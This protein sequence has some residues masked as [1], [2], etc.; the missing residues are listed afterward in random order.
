MAEEFD[1]NH[2]G[3]GTP[4][5]NR[6]I[7]TTEI[8]APNGV[9]GLDGSG[10][11][12][13]SVIP[14]GTDTKKTKIGVSDT[15]EGFLNDKLVESDSIGKIIELDGGTGEQTMQFVL[16]HAGVLTAFAQDIF[17]DA[18]TGSTGYLTY[19][20]EGIVSSVHVGQG[21]SSTSKR[22]AI[23]ILPDDFRNFTS[24]ALSIASYR[25]GTPTSMTASMFK[26]PALPIDIGV[27]TKTLDANV[28]AQSILPT[29]NDTFEEFKFTPSGT[30]AA[31][32]IVAVFID[33]TVA[34]GVYSEILSI[35]LKYYR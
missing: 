27:D 25:F 34:N 19:E 29:V 31:G 16:K 2:L 10:Q 5:R 22:F 15:T 3:T 30:Y 4:A 20:A 1:R 26:V 33:D 12:S 14:S 35:K 13:S 32:D 6:P 21:V 23:F 8:D 18:A 9:A 17:F 7:R 11:L 24:D 28:N